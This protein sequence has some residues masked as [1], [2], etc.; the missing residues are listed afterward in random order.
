MIALVDCNNFYVSCERIFDPSLEGRPV[1][2]LSNNDGCVIARSE[3]AKALGIAMGA[4]VFRMES[5]ITRHGVRVF[6]SN[7]ALYGDLSGRVQAILREFSPQVETYSIDEAFLVLQL[8]PGRDLYAYGDEIRLAIRRRLGI[9]VTVGIASTKSLAKLANRFAKK[10]KGTGPVYCLD[11]NEKTAEALAATP[12]GD[13]W[14]I[15]A[16]HSRRL[17]WMGIATAADFIEKLKPGWIRNNL[18]VLGERLYRELRGI[19]SIAW[20]EMPQPKKGICTARSFGKLLTAKED[21]REAVAS[22]AGACALKL[23]QQKSCASLV[24]VLLQ[25]NVHR[26]RE[27]Q[28]ARSVSL[29]LP[30]PSNSSRAII[31]RALAGLDGIYR[32]GY[33]FKKA[34]VIVSEL[35]P[36]CAVQRGLFDDCDHERE[37]RMMQALDA[38]NARFGRDRLRF[39][40]QGFAREW[41]LRQMNLSPCYTTRIE[42]VLRIKI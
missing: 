37:A 39:A 1:V 40:V 13:V 10:N 9:P 7:Y 11:T 25:T 24:Q 30:L 16:Q 19:P 3:E 27:P 12:I 32:S 38:V 14:G 26:V 5:F 21:I 18:T 4:P 17:Q 8:P 42:E 20:E 41:K 28:Y 35:V 34:G 15:G 6:S 23:R 31:A 2:V 36:E 29:A 22:Y 33:Q